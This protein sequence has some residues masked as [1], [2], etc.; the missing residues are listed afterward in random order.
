MDFL[1]ALV[2][3]SCMLVLAFIAHLWDELNKINNRLSNIKIMVNAYAERTE[4][5]LDAAQR[6]ADIND[7]MIKYYDSEKED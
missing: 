1:T 2:A 7:R 3:I 4:R 6:V 5:V